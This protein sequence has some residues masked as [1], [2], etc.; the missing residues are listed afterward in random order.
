MSGIVGIFFRDGR[1]VDP[2]ELSQMVGTISHRGPDGSG[3]WHTG[4]V[5]LGHC[6]LWTT[7]ESLH[8]QLPLVNSTGDVI[9]TSDARIDNR[10]ELLTALAMY[11]QPAHEISDSEIILR[12]YEKWGESCPEKLLGDFV[13]AIWDKRLKKIICARDH[14]GMRSFYYYL[15]EKI[16][17][18]ASEI[19]A[20]IQLPHVPSRINEVRIADYLAQVYADKTSTLYQQIF[21]LP[22]AH[23]MT[24]VAKQYQVNSYWSLDLSNDLQLKSDEEYACSFY[25]I[26]EEAVR[27][28]LR[29]AYKIGFAL[30]G[31]L[32]SSSIVCS[33]RHLNS[34]FSEQPIQTFSAIFPGLQQEEL[35]KIDERKYIQTV[36]SMGGFSPHYIRADNVSPLTD[37]DKLLSFTDEIYFAPNLFM[38][39]VLYSAAKK[40]GVRVYLDG[41]DGDVTVSHGFEHMTDLF[42]TGRWKSLLTEAAAIS[43]QSIISAKPRQIIW[44]HGIRPLIPES[45]INIKRTLWR[46]EPLQWHLVNPDL[47]HRIDYR[48]RIQSLKNGGPAHRLNAREVHESELNAAYLTLNLELLDK[49]KA[50]FS[51]DLRLPFFDR[52]LVE[53]CLAIPPDQKLSQGWTRNIFRRAMDGILPEEVQWRSTKAFFNANFKRALLEYERETLDRIILSEMEII[54]PFVNLPA[55]HTAYHRFVDQPSSGVRDAFIVYSAITL[56]L[57]L[58]NVGV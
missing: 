37:F 17:V 40:D 41:I 22:P 11:D 4:S 2:T 13:F 53:F 18:F 39:W 29:S 26:F 5:G 6:M 20:L 25:E 34:K 8:E 35:Q 38:Y 49:V 52:R 23:C 48:D 27:C 50:A 46:K 55:L 14:M 19:K 42:R 9:L 44:Q 31:G 28:R 15:S 36:L 56:A 16:F 47:V 24:V 1:T 51:L 12:A 58:K 43:S 30:S 3:I 21:R 54:E 57:W 33:A 10:K 32:D 7:P 45:I